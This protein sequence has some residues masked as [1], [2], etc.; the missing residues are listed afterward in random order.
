MEVEEEV[1]W[2]PLGVEMEGDGEGDDDLR[3]SGFMG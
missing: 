1:N 2:E 3:K